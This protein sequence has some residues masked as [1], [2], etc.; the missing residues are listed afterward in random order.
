[1]DSMAKR[2]ATFALA[3]Q[4]SLEMEPSE[5]DEANDAANTAEE[6]KTDDWHS[7]GEVSLDFWIPCRDDRFDVAAS[8]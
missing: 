8:H 6:S 1:M 5:N 4:Q 2:Q 7:E 3:D